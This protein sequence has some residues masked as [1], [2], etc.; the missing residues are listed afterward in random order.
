MNGSAEL[1]AAGETRLLLL[2]ADLIRHDLVD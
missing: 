2:L 1:K